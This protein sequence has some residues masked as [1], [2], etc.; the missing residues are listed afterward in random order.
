ML[1]FGQKYNFVHAFLPLFYYA[2]CV[3]TLVLYQQVNI[4]YTYFLEKIDSISA[5]NP[6]KQNLIT[7]Q[8]NFT[9]IALTATNQIHITYHHSTI[10]DA[11]IEVQITRETP[12]DM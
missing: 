12:N 10:L 6:Y 7:Q 3:F 9:H 2:I 5:D 8:I 1:T 11:N 4:L